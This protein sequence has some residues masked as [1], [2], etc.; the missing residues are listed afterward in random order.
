M[1]PNLGESPGEAG[2][3]G[4]WQLQLTRTQTLV[5]ATLGRSLHHVDTGAGGGGHHCINLLPAQPYDIF[6][7]LV[8][9]VPYMFYKF[10]QKFL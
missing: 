5:A 10:I 7:N 1:L 4:G 9:L 2:G 3:G 6:K 8:W